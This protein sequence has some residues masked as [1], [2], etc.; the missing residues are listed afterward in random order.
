MVDGLVSFSFAVLSEFDE[1]SREELIRLVRNS[2]IQEDKDLHL[3]RDQPLVSSSYRLPPPP[4][5]FNSSV[6]VEIDQAGLFHLYSL[7]LRFPILQTGGFLF[8]NWDQDEPQIQGVSGAPRGSVRTFGNFTFGHSP[9]YLDPFS[10]FDYLGKW[11]SH[12]S[13]LQTSPNEF[14]ILNARKEINGRRGN[15]FLIGIVN[16]SRDSPSCHSV[17]FYLIRSEEEEIV[18]ISHRRPKDYLSCELLRDEEVR[19][20]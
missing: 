19:R 20:M 14:E 5:L 17:S 1:T 6:F 7:A 10:P 11:Y 2:G 18:K 12:H 8:G 3:L 4:I 16:L 9:S 13:S 15:P